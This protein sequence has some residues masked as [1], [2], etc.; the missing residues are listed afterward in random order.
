MTK[1]HITVYLDTETKKA[2]EKRAKSELMSLDEMVSDILRRSVLSYKGPKGSHD[3]LDDTFLTY[4]TR[5]G[6]A[7]RRMP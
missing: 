1:K 3:K 5:K 6:R 2:L 4:F 7:R